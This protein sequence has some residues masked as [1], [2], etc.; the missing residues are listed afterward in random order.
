[1]LRRFRGDEGSIG[2]KDAHPVRTPRPLVSE[3]VML[4]RRVSD[5]PPGWGA[6]SFMPVPRRR[7]SYIRWP[8]FVVALIGSLAAIGFAVH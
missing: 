6:L 3:H 2:A 7:S 4:L 5:L 8:M 1:M